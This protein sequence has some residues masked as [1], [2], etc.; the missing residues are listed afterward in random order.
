MRGGNKESKG[1]SSSLVHDTFE[2]RDDDGPGPGKRSLTQ[3][4][5]PELQTGSAVSL[6][7]QRKPGASNAGPAGSPDAVHAA[8]ERG[9]AGSSTRLPFADGTQRACGR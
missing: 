6:L 1:S 7:V 5:T 8:A 4:L 3:R 9:T 2:R